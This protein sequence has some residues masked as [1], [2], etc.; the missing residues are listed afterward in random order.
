MA[1]VLRES[2]KRSDPWMTVVIP[3][4]KGHF[5]WFLVSNIFFNP[6][7]RKSTRH[8]FSSYPK[9]QFLHSLGR[10]PFVLYV[11]SMRGECW[12]FII[13]DV[14]NGFSTSVFFLNT[15]LYMMRNTAVFFLHSHCADTGSANR[16]T[17]VLEFW[18]I[19]RM[20]K[21]RFNVSSDCPPFLWCL[22]Y[23]TFFC[24]RQYGKL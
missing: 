3:P 9:T 8:L 23:S 24:P 10:I 12:T 15:F 17:T 21:S 5:S 18:M 1:F 13:R 7:F 22:Y 20:R 14:Q 6:L 16:S 11:R 4:P 19:T 2:K